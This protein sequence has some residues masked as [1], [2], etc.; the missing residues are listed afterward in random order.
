MGI[1]QLIGRWLRLEDELALAQD[2]QPRNT[3][4]VARLVHELACT[5][6]EIHALQA[7]SRQRT[8]AVSFAD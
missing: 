8:D 6:R 7:A 4:R 1:E 2:A 5:A 3:G